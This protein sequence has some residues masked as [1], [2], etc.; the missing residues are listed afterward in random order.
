MTG[1][2]R[3]VWDKRLK[4]GE[5]VLWTGQPT[6][7]AK[8]IELLFLAIIYALIAAITWPFFHT[9]INQSGRNPALFFPIAAAGFSWFVLAIPATLLGLYVQHYAITNLRAL[10]LTQFGL[11]ILWQ[12]DLTLETTAIRGALS[13]VVSIV[14]DPNTPSKKRKRGQMFVGISDEDYEKILDALGVAVRMRA[15]LEASPTASATI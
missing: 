10:I 4:P 12:S 15:N 3:I 1:D 5:V 6:R 14:V 8:C 13:S 11:R 7:K 2:S 9:L